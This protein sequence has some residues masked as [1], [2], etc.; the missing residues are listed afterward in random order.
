MSCLRKSMAERFTKESRLISYFLRHHPEE[1][2]GGADSQG[3]VNIDSLVKE[4]AKKYKHF[5]RE[6]LDIIVAEDEKTRYKIQESK[7]RAS[8]GHSAEYV[9]IDFKRETPPDTLFHG[10][11]SNVVSLIFKEGIKAQRRHYVHLSELEST[12]KS[13][14]TRHGP[15][16]LIMIDSKEMHDKGIEFYKADNGVWLTRFVDPAYILSIQ[17]P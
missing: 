17:Y 5:D 3:W 8:Q 2:E 15:P 1:I 16:A 10:T 14:G 7:I 4:V 9:K 13:V 11:S 12:A 6:I